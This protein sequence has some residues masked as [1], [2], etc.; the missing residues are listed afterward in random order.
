MFELI[1]FV[2]LAF[3]VEA[4]GLFHVDLLVKDTI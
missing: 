2:L 4:F 3:D 1:D